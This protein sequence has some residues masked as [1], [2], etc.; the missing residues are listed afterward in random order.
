MSQSHCAEKVF[1]YYK[2]SEPVA[3]LNLIKGIEKKDFKLQ[4]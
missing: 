1:F 2:F 3:I 4:F